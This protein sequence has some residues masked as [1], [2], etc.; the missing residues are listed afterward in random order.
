MTVPPVMWFS[1]I[2]SND[3]SVVGGKGVNLGIMYNLKLPVPPGFVV[4]A[5]SYKFFL[6]QTGIQEKI[7]SILND[8]DVEDTQKLEDSA[9]V[10]QE[11]ILDA[12]MPKVIK[13][14]IVEAYDDMNVDRA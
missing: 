11:I 13:E 8:L 5:Q 10:I 9:K 7:L 6:D 12:E 3:N 14:S 4:T 1:E 2:S